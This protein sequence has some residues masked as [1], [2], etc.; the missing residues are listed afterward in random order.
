MA[1]LPEDIATRAPSGPSQAAREA[2]SSASI[3]RTTDEFFAACAGLSATT[4]VVCV[5][6]S[7]FAFVRFQTVKGKPAFSRFAAMPRPIVPRPNNAI[8]GFMFVVLRSLHHL[9]AQWRCQ[10]FL[11]DHG[12]P[13][14]PAK[15]RKLNLSYIS[16]LESDA[17]A[18]GQTVGTHEMDVHHARLAMSSEF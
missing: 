4:A 8:D 10:R 9:R 3:A 18:E 17:F 6:N 15:F 2:A 11:G 7:A 1:M 12:V 14:R 16:G 13:Q 5:N